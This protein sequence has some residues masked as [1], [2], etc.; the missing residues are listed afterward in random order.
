MIFDKSSHLVI[1][2]I[3]IKNDPVSFKPFIDVS[4]KVVMSQ[5]VPGKGVKTVSGTK[6]TLSISL[7]NAPNLLSLNEYEMSIY[8]QILESVQDL[9]VLM[10]S[11]LLV[12]NPKLEACE[13]SEENLQKRLAMILANPIKEEPIE[14]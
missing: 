4:Y 11:M 6:G 13:Y 12:S 5:V 14:E 10:I 3:V 2:S 7:D 1:D 8:E 9:R